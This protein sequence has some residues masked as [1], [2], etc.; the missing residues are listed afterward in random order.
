VTSKKHSE[1][2]DTP[3]LEWIAGAIGFVLFAAAMA[4]MITNSF[5]PV[6]PLIVSVRQE[7]PVAVPGGF[8]VEFEVIN[9]GDQTAAS[10][11]IEASLRSKSAVVEQHEVTLDFLAPKS[12]ARAGVFLKTNPAGLDL[13]IVAAGYQHP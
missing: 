2:D 10:V 13:E 11:V 9:S 5:R 6:E 7:A 4:V 8:R 3:I 12:S 1:D